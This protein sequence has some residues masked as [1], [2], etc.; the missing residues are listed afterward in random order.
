MKQRFYLSLL[1]VGLILSAR[2]QDWQ[3]DYNKAKEMALIENRKLILV[4]QGSDWC[5]PCMK[6]DKQIWSNAEFI[7]Y[8]K[9]HYVMLLADFPKRKGNELSKEQKAKNNALAEKY[10]KNGFFPLVVIMNSEGKVIGQTGYKN[11]TVDEYID[12]L[13]AF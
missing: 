12:H 1:F 9:D 2:A 4:F 10:N 6:L 3:T 7:R 8:A 13:N 5:T 11:M